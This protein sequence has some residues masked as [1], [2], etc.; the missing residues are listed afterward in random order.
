MIVTAIVAV[1]IYIF[2]FMSKTCKAAISLLLLRDK[3]KDNCIL[4]SSSHSSYCA[5][6]KEYYHQSARDATRPPENPS[7]CWSNSGTV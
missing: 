6:V 3:R 5:S 4:L 7:A 2:N 1:K